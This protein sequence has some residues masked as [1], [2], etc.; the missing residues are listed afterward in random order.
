MSLSV[1]ALD[2]LNRATAETGLAHTGNDVIDEIFSK[3]L[4]A[5]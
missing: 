1:E 3:A 2:R 4:L 5:Q